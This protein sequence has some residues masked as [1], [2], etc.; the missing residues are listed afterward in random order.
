MASGLTL[1]RIQGKIGG[2]RKPRQREPAGGCCRNLCGRLGDP[3]KKDFKGGRLCWG[4]S[5]VQEKGERSGF[6]REDV[7]RS[8]GH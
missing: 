2:A 7:E 1:S 4:L 5:E 6:R 3:G 8:W